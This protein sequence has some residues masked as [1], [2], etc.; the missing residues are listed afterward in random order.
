MNTGSLFSTSGHL[1][2]HTLAHLE[3]GIMHPASHARGIIRKTGCF[4]AIVAVW[5]LMSVRL[6]A[7]AECQDAHFC[8]PLEVQATVA[9]GPSVLVTWKIYNNYPDKVIIHRAPSGSDF[10]IERPP[11]ESGFA[12]T[13]AEVN[14]LYS[15]RVCAHYDDEPYCSNIVQQWLPAP[16]ASGQGTGGSTGANV[17]SPDQIPYA[18]DARAENISP[19]L[20]QISW[21]FAGPATSSI[22][23]FVRVQRYNYYGPSD[24]RGSMT[25]QWELPRGTTSLRDETVQPFREYSYEVC[26]QYEWQGGLACSPSH[27]G[28]FR[29]LVAIAGAPTDVRAAFVSNG[30][31]INWTAND[32]TVLWFEVERQEHLDWKV[33]SPKIATRRDTYFTDTNPPPPQSAA[34][35]RILVYRVCAGNVAGRACSGPAGAEKL[36]T[37]G[38]ALV[39]TLRIL[40]VVPSRFAKAHANPPMI[41]V[42][43]TYSGSDPMGDWAYRNDGGAW[44]TVRRPPMILKPGTAQV[45]IPSSVFQNSAR[46]VDVL[47]NN[48]QSQAIG[49]IA[50][51]NVDPTVQVPSREPP[52]PPDAAPKS[53]PPL[54]QQAPG[55]S[56]GPVF[57][58]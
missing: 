8:A 4:L 20:V 9:G 52:R 50:V 34:L 42:F 23:R 38:E 2:T 3:R 14:V 24:V 17:P 39:N 35:P 1:L 6:V 26:L 5:G 41:E 18:K 11:L 46:S 31:H 54:Q 32:E 33:I 43:L 25:R 40:Q 27:T 21:T 16:T 57:P 44:V 51:M 47:L 12:D 48:G 30:V 13:S 28:R 56:T 22:V 37:P 19:T 10:P 49:T 29:T 55:K 45:T 58:R 53:V 36:P 15:Y 7:A